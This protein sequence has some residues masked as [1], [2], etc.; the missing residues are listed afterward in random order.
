LKGGRGAIMS[1]SSKG[2]IVTPMGRKMKPKIKF[3]TMNVSLVASSVREFW[4]GIKEGKRRRGYIMNMKQQDDYSESST[5]NGEQGGK[6]KTLDRTFL[7]TALMELG[8]G[9]SSYSGDSR[10]INVRWRRKR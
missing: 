9:R 7:F 8:R 5:K 10:I 6:K 1:L 2:R 3:R 4:S